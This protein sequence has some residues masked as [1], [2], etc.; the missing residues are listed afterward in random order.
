MHIESDTKLDYSD[1][2][3]RPK[4]S[5]LESR[6]EVKL[7]RQFKF[8]HSQRTLEVIPIIAANM[9]GVGTISMHDILHNYSCLTAL[10]KYVNPKDYPNSP[11][12]VK[13]CDNMYHPNIY[14]DGKVC[15]SILHDGVDQYGY[16]STGERWNPSHS[17]SSIL[18]SIISMLPMPNFESPANIDASVMCKDNYD[19]YKRKIY[20]LVSDSHKL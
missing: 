12:S 7:T 13:F 9:D 17:V 18:L 4:R 3:L 15:I 2:L 14:P 6:K 10:T 16:E 19:S 20:K 1:V 5:T 8:P 11:P